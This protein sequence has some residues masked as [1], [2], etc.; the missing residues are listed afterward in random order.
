M[1]VCAAISLIKYDKDGEPTDSILLCGL[2][3]H[4][5]IENAAKMNNAL[6]QEARNRGGVT[7]GFINH[8]GVFIT[9]EEAYVEAVDC[10][11]LT[12]Q[13]VTEH[14]GGEL[15]FSEDLY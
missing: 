8:M 10:G 12:L 14:Q 9:R 11:Q 6:L 1:V 15:L 5:I 4:I 2:R 13:A 3:H 7:Q